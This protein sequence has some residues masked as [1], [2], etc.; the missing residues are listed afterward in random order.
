MERNGDLLDNLSCLR[1]LFRRAISIKHWG[2]TMEARMQSRSRTSRK[3][4]N[5]PAVWAID[6]SN[7]L[8]LSTHSSVLNERQ[9]Y[10]KCLAWATLTSSISAI[11]SNCLLK[12]SN[13]LNQCMTKRWQ[14][15][16]EWQK[17]SVTSAHQR[18]EA[19][20]PKNTEAGIIVYLHTTWQW[21][22]PIAINN[23]SNLKSKVFKWLKYQVNRLN[24]FFTQ[25]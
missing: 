16:G 6:I 1:P 3:C 7:S 8:G 4:T 21:H 19:V 11:K 15:S 20:K 5:I 10:L 14:K 23:R 18:I 12:E 13:N 9:S 17:W 24:I 22:N 2:N 25:P